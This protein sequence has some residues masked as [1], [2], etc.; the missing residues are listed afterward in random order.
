MRMVPAPNEVH[1]MRAGLAAVGLI[2]L[3]AGPGPA[4]VV[5]RL[6]D[7]FDD[8]RLI[9]KAREQPGVQKQDVAMDA[10]RAKL[11]RLKERDLIVLFGP[12][13]AMPAK[14]YAMPVAQHRALVFSGLSVDG[15]KDHQEFYVIKDVAGLEVYYGTDGES[16]VAVVVYLLA[17]KDFPKLTADNLDKRLAWDQDHW[18][19]LLKHYEN[20][21]PAVFPWE[22]DRDELAKL[23]Q[24]DFAVDAKAKLE[25]WIASGKALGY[26]YRHTEG[27][28]DWT[29][30]RPDGTLA[31][32]ASRGATDGP[33]V[34]FTWHFAN[35]SGELRL[36]TFAYQAGTLESRRWQNPK[37]G[38][39]L[40]YETFGSWCWYGK[41]GKP[42]RFEW[43]DNGDGIPDWY[44][45][46]ED[47]LEHTGDRKAMEKRKPLKVQESWAV[48]PKL[49]PEA[50]RIP[51]QPDL[52]LPLRRTKAKE[53]GML[54]FTDP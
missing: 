10:F 21:L 23:H 15:A 37:T 49:I 50:S 1:P 27:S 18:D 48:N 34:H 19:R 14:T 47:G 4:G 16:P 33:P 53:Y 42:V 54:Y 36:E 43:D 32:S 13:Q 6:D 25:A 45:T 3:L 31:R 44:V 11:Y 30:H 24:G 5:E 28:R 26:T 2:L 39:N 52:R 46:G 17:G 12:P 22:I 8:T 40:R 9:Q 7:E 35:G 38:G 41:D 29:W 20:R 51:D